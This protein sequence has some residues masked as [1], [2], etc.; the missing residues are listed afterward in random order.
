MFYTFDC[1]I[2]IVKDHTCLINSSSVHEQW[3]NFY[4][5]VNLFK[6]WNN[7]IQYDLPALAWEWATKPF[8][9][10]QNDENLIG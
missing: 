6:I 9:M 5:G 7:F 3:T 8:K 1:C 10:F 2:C 4:P